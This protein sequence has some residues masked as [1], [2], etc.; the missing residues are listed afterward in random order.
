MKLEFATRCATRLIDRFSPFTERLEVVGSIRRRRP[1][2][3]DFDL[4]A[5]PKVSTGRDLFGAPPDP[6]N[7]LADEVRRVCASEGWRL[8][9]DG[10]EF[11]SFEAKGIQV[12]LWYATPESFASISLSRTG[13]KEHNVWL[14]M[15]A[16]DRGSKWVPHHGLYAGNRLL[17]C[18]T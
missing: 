16:I 6:R 2:V 4:V 15:R 11:S 18:P 3:G 17:A 10:V 1:E 13:S 14:A 8:I 12:D 5:V 7:L 9:R